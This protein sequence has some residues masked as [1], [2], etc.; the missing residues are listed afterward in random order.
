M[1]GQTLRDWVHRYNEGGIDGL[2]SR[3]SPGR[4]S[5]LIDQQKT[6]LKAKVVAGPDAVKWTWETGREAKLEM[7]APS[8]SGPAVRQLRHGSEIPASISVPPDCPGYEAFW[9]RMTA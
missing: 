4:A 8:L 2:K 7:S 9:Q 3:S 1:D 6:E 5:L